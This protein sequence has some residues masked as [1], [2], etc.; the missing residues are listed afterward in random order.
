M[1][2]RKNRAVRPS[3]TPL[4][5]RALLSG[6]A[7]RSPAL[8]H[9]SALPG[10]FRASFIGHFDAGPDRFNGSPFTVHVTSNEGGSST[11]MHTNLRMAISTFPASNSPVTGQAAFID[12]NV[13]TT[14]S[15]LIL[16]LKGD[17]ASLDAKGRPTS[18]TWTVD[19]ASGGL[20]TNATGTG[21][22]TIGYR[23]GRPTR[24]AAASGTAVVRFSGQL[25]TTRLTNVVNNL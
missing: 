23:P 18:A 11:S 7:A 22:V 9:R 19:S 6:L 20:Y 4:E 21:T 12:R 13:T 3:L 10:A 8:A 16:D 24:G 17:P 15:T 2:R 25:L 14:G 1:S 5:G